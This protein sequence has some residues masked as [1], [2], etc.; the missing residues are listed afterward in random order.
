MPQPDALAM[1]PHTAAHTGQG[2]DEGDTLVDAVIDGEMLAE[3]TTVGDALDDVLTEGG[4][5][6]ALADV[7]TN[8]GLGL[9]D[10]TTTG[11]ARDGE[12]TP[13]VAREEGMLE[14]AHADSAAKVLANMLDVVVALA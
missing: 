12:G 3:A 7:G 14:F 2:E 4:F 5:T 10:G 9:G 1:A 11:G 13:S 6:V 8:D